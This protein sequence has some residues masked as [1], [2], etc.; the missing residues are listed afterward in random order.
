MGAANTME[1]QALIGIVR[2]LAQGWNGN[3]GFFRYGVRDEMI[4][5]A[6]LARR[7]V[8]AAVFT[9]VFLGFGGC[10]SGDE[11]SGRTMD[12]SVH[13]LAEPA[14][15]NAV[16]AG[17]IDEIKRIIDAGAKLDA[18][19][20]LDRTPLHMAAFYGRTKIAE[21][22]IAHGADVNARDQIAMTPLHA[23]V[24][25]GERAAA[26]AGEPAVVPLLLDGKA[27]LQA[28]N[29]EGQTA[30]HLAAATGQPKLTKF[31]IER[32]ADPHERDFDGRTPLDY[33]RKNY[34]P[35]TRAV[36]EGRGQRTE[37]RR[38]RGNQ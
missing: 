4:R 31:L 25:S 9:I 23:A 8:L 24:I 1:K 34:H 27:D 16:I 7:P 11:K 14:L 5:Q 13:L 19:G 37:D 32:G 30:L 15:F 2:R 12:G 29:E 17:D 38:Q 33:A 21:L 26:L 36:L 18:V 6:I 3:R 10:G 22:L 20:A 35:Q 28:K